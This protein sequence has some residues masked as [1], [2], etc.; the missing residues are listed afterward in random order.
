M[1]RSFLKYLLSLCILLL[2]VYGQLYAQTYQEFDRSSLIQILKG[3]ELASYGIQ[4]NDLASTYSSSDRE[5]HLNL[6]ATDIE[7]EKNKFASSRKKVA[8]SIFFSAAF[9][10]LLLANFFCYVKTCLLSCKHF[11]YTLSK[12][13]YL[14]FEVFRI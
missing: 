8:S 1:I 10:A 5:R 3:T 7:E 2:S 14:I 9:F 12:R 11:S 6:E 4:Q 13:R